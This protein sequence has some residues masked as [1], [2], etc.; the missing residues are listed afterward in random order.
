MAKRIELR[1]SNRDL[2]KEWGAGFM[3][4]KNKRGDLRHPLIDSGK[5]NKFTRKGQ[6][7]VVK[8]LKP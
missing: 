4:G 2:P 3:M 5:P 1:S 8:T 7:V 6:A